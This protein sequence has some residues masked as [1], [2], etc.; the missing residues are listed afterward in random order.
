MGWRWDRETNNIARMVKDM[1]VVDLFCGCGGM[2]LGF[3]NAGFEIVAAFD[4]WAP[5]IAV[6]QKNFVH[7]IYNYDISS[8][9]AQ[10]IISHL[11]ADIIIGGPPCQDF[12]TAG[13]MDEG[14]GRAQLTVVFSQIIA[15]AKPEFFV[16]ENVARAKKSKAYEKAMQIFREAG[17]GLTTMLLDA[18]HCGVPQSR[19]RYFVIGELNGQDEFLQKHLL[20]N[21]SETPM[22]IHDYLGDSLGTEY[23]FRVPTNYSRRGVYSIYEPAVTVRGVDR[24]IPKGYKKHPQ[25]PV[26][27]GPQVR[28]LTVKERSYLQ[29]FPESFIWEGSKTDLNQMIGNAVPVNL[30]K[31]VA[32]ALNHYIS[33]RK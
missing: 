30:A 2:S 22:T 26:E 1:K 6:Y 28:A 11:D 13:L 14:I 25:D 3:Q 23:Y 27:I 8:P 21:L 5:A 9:E 29:T 19:K 24:P 32:E 18:S 31:Y 33:S 7:P 16:M 20:A 17:Y 4:N 12:S 15:D 10:E